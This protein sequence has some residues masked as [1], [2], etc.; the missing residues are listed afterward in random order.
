MVNPRRSFFTFIC[1]MMVL[2]FPCI[3]AYAADEEDSNIDEMEQILDKQS[4]KE[5]A[6]NAA[7]PVIDESPLGELSSLKNLQAFS[8]IAIIQRKFLPK[9]KRFEIYGGLGTTVNNAF[10]MNFG[11]L[12]RL[13]YHLSE[14]WGVEGSFM[15]LSSSKR[16]AVDDL[17]TVHGIDTDG[18]VSPEQFYGVDLLWTP[19]YG[20]VSVFE[21]RI[22]PF[23]LY[24][25]GGFGLTKT[26]QNQ[27]EPT[28]HVG[29]GQK[30]AISKS[31]ALRWDF[32]WNFYNATYR[33]AGVDK[34][35]NFDNLFMT[36]GMSFFFP[37]AT[38]R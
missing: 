18:L 35:G 23:D 24:L 13:G 14:S 19:V 34:T 22:V 25:S 32:S 17:S 37:E 27:S 33:D 31:L 4:D 8:D 1:A 38:Y 28:F 7:A 20:K 2:Q 3:T 6:E 21:S 29:A 10:F 16:E 15:Y 36:L 11:L 5:D 9:S 12:L 26:N 30:F